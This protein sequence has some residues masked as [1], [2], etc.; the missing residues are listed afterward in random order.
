[1][2]LKAGDDVVAT[3]VIN[4]MDGRGVPGKELPTIGTEKIELPTDEAA[5]KAE[6]E[7]EEIPVEL[8][9]EN[10]VE[11]PAEE[12]RSEGASENDEDD[13]V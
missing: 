2:Q 10:P 1:M 7:T 8:A 3:S 5:K 4:E 12:L 13:G 6:L 9:D 11:L